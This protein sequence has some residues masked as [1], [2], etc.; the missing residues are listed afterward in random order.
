MKKISINLILI[1]MLA[2]ML[3]GCEMQTS[4]NV[5]VAATKQSVVVNTE[6]VLQHNYAQYF[7]ITEN[8]I[9][10][11]VKEEYLDKSNLSSEIGSYIIT[12]T[13]KNKIASLIVNVEK[14]TGIEI[15]VS[16]ESIEI[17]NV[18]VY[19]HDYKQYFSIVDNGETI[20]VIDEYLDLSNLRTSEGNYRI[21]CTYKN[22]TAE[23]NV[24]VIEATYQL[25]LSVREITIK[26]SEVENYDFTALFT[27][28]VNGKITPINDSM[29]KSN[30]SSNV[31][32][33]QYTVT[34]GETSMT[35]TVNV[36]SDH[37]VKIINSYLMYEIEESKIDSFDFTSLFTIY[38]DNESRQ[39]QEEM[40]DK[41]SLDNLNEDN[42]YEIKISYTEGQA[43]GIGSC[44]IKVIPDYET[45][46]NTKHITIYPNSEH[47]DLTTLFEIKKGNEIIP[48]TLDMITG[49][50]NTSV[51]GEN[52]IT[53]TFEG[54]EYTSIVEIKQGV[55]INYAKSD[56]VKVS[57]GTS[58]SSYLFENDFIVL[59]NGINFTNISQY[60]D[61][62]EVDFGTSGIYTAT[63]SIP[64]KDTSLGY[65]EVTYFSKEITYEVVDITYEIKVNKELVELP[66]GTTEYNP[67]DNLTVKVNGRNQ[68]L[69]KV[70]SQASVLATYAEVTSEPIDYLSIGVQTV[71]L[72]IYV[73]GPDKDPVEV[74]FSIIIKSDIN[75]E[76]NNTLIFEGDTLYTKDLFTITLNGEEIEVTQDMI[77]GKVDS[78]N[79]GV[80]PV[81]ITYQGIKR[82]VNVVVL[83]KDLIGRYK[84]KLTTIP[85]EGSTD[86]D[87]YEDTGV[88]A[89]EIQDL[90]IAEDGRISVDGVLA[91]ILYGIDENTLY[92]KI[93]GYEF[94]LYYNNGIVLIDPNND[95]KLGFIDSK[96]PLIYFRED[97]WEID[98]KV[99]INSLDIHVL[100]SSYACYSLDIF[101]LSSKIS[102]DTLWYGLMIDLY[103]KMNS[104]TN[105][106]VTHGEVTFSDDWEKQEGSHSSLTYNG[107]VYEFNM[108]SESTGKIGA[109]SSEVVYKYAGQKFS[110]TYNGQEAILSVDIYEGFLLTVGGE[111]IINVAGAAVRNQKYGGVNYDTDEVLIIDEGRASSAPYSHKL[112]LNVEDGTFTYV[113]K[114]LYFGRYTSESMMIFFDGYG[115]GLINFDTKQY[116][117]T[118]INYIEKN[119]EIEIVYLDTKPTFTH[120]E[121]A[122]VFIDA[123]YTTLTAKY[124][125]DENIRGEKFVN[126]YLTDGAIIEILSYTMKP[127]SN[128]VLGRKALFDM[129]KVYL[130][131]GEITDNNIK[132]QMIDITDINFAEAGF[133]HFSVTCTVGEQEVVMHYALQIS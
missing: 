79:P 21:S 96:R 107:K 89:R 45:V 37:I 72:N 93:G 6:E 78:F 14:L 88:A 56:V 117:V 69:T 82:S 84:T 73:F 68:K 4:T 129:I 127:Y 42:I 98:D 133:Y 113:E 76:C 55:I 34:L 104:D 66:A 29:I 110:G 57:K 132:I 31:G 25:K 24:K 122:T 108:V 130:P 99:T 49:T 26:Q 41:S 52:V 20:N 80:Y 22:N 119:N 115:T 9:S 43:T 118:K 3:I 116:G 106:L 13:Y 48:V 12:C 46:V 61:S 77:E 71:T 19:I 109:Q 114:D 103:E 128:K 92:I 15:T 30:V 105:Y 59:I 32:T 53:L 63:I 94:T 62:S 51:V 90:F 5:E 18:D 100:Q 95:I 35:L 17:N 125:H 75:I 131:T 58:K 123:L 121:Y 10:K 102:N 111:I 64:Y 87:G 97:M 60:I 54:K 44:F 91:T 36:I 83:N 126:E 23:L 38:V 101:E 8:G 47:I 86:E 1:I 16:Q 28:V 27:A 85:V 11:V 74:S 50:I 40:I 39:V 2:L 33:Y 7:T 124:F 81:T 65:T 70:A 112:I 120:G 67:F